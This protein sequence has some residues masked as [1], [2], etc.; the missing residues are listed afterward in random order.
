MVANKETIL[1]ARFD[2]CME[3]RF[4]AA[5]A[6][7][8]Y[9]GAIERT[10]SHHFRVVVTVTGG[11]LNRAGLLIDFLDLK[12]LLAKEVKR[13]NG[14]FLNQ[15]VVEFQLN[16]LSPSAE[17]LARVLHQNLKACLPQGVRLSSVQVFEAPG[18]SATYRE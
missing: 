5:H 17:N 15:D 7:R 2:V 13:L 4:R 11:K 1:S 9:H 12:Q 8:D 14:R 3:T 16:K 18:C 10:H 6:L